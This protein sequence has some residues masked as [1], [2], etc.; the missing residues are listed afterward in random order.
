MRVLVVLLALTALCQGGSLRV[1]LGTIRSRRQVQQSTTASALSPQ[2]I[3]DQ[4]LDKMIQSL[5]VIQKQRL[6]NNNAPNPLNDAPTSTP[7]VWAASPP[8]AVACSPCA[9][10]CNTKNPCKIKIV[11]SVYRNNN[12]C[13]C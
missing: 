12:C 1:G 8:A 9:P 5:M 2:Y 4:E 3:S 13:T 6:S 7:T 10:Q 11:N